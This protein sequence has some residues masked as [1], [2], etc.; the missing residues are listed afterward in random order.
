MTGHISKHGMDFGP[1]V[2]AWMKS[3]TLGD[4]K[5]LAARIER[6]GDDASEIWEFAN[7][8]SEIEYGQMPRMGSI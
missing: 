4:V 5:S 7:A 8:L 2:K 3:H 1:D 6:K